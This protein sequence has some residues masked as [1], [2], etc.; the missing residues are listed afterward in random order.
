MARLSSH[1]RRLLK[2]QRSLELAV[3]GALARSCRIAN[4]KLGIVVIHTDN[5]AVAA[6]LRQLATRLGDEFRKGGA[7]V[8]EI[9]VR[10]Q[11]RP[12]GPAAAPSP[13]SNRLGVAA[14]QRLAYLADGLGDASPLKSALRRL[15]ERSR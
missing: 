13:G 12:A 1:A 5:G 7:E 4:F 8:T 3:P 9:R 2:L 15:I 6:K 10:V 11:P 14:K